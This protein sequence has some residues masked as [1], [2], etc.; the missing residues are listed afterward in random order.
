[1]PLLGAETIYGLLEGYRLCWIGGRFS[2][3]KSSLAF[4]LARYW[5]EKGYRLVT[6][7]KTVWGDPLDSVSLRDG[8][9][10]DAVLLLDEGGLWLKSNRIV[11][12][13]AA[14]A[15]KMRLIVLIP[16]FFPPAPRFRVVNVQPLFT[17]RHLKIPLTVYRWRVVSGA[18][19]DQ[20]HFIWAFPSRDGIYGVYSRQDP[21]EDPLDI[22][23]WME[24]RLD[25]FRAY[26]GRGKMELPPD[27]EQTEV[28]A[29]MEEVWGRVADRLM[30]KR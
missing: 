18:Y 24:A 12:G 23:R 10:L 3:G 6:N 19:A 16:S 4:L 22:V 29:D 8:G 28:W 7:C 9:Y 15:A 21:G 17:F 25:D 30:K 27:R 2:G 13:L 11:E 14:Y 20:G 5:L 26:H 1:M